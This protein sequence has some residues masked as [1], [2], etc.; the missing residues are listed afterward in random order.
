MN[1]EERTTPQVL[2]IERTED[3]NGTLNQN[4]AMSWGLCGLKLSVVQLR[5]GSIHSNALSIKKNIIN[6]PYFIPSL[7]GIL[8]ADAI[9]EA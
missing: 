3:A 7:I 2:R 5:V 4:E 9:F 1:A 8:N 6:S